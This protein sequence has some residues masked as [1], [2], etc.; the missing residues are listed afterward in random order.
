M[1]RRFIVGNW[2][3]HNTISQAEILMKDLLE[4]YYPHDSVELAVAP[5][6]VALSAVSQLVSST[7]ITLAAQNMCAKDEGAFT[8]E[9]SP[10]MLQEVG[11]RYVIIGHSER[12]QLFGETDL[13]INEKLHGALRHSLSPIFC[14]G[15]RLEER[16][17]NQTRT[18]IHNQLQRGL[19]GF[20]IDDLLHLTI[21]YEPVWAIGTG[22]AA[23]VE[24]A[25]EVHA[26][27]RAFLATQWGMDS[28]QIRIIY[29]GSVSPDNA[30]LLFQSSEING[31]LVGK[32]CLNS[33]SFVKI[34]ALAVLN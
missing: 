5:P 19:A 30:Q 17:A 3:M 4:S 26:H 33:E 15:E 27:I 34:A 23:T 8:G 13:M 11:C 9:I 32:A 16:Q 25:A 7:S 10:L 31:A 22:H 12:R 14:V 2:K 1:G 21:A 28:N 20:N 29:G 24:Q 18:I 6:F